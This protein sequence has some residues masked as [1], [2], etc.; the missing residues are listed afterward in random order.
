MP[1]QTTPDH[2][3]T[4]LTH[5]LGHLAQLAARTDASEQRILEAAEK[6]LVEVTADLDRLRPAIT[7]DEQ[8]LDDYQELTLE[9]GQLEIVIATARENLGPGA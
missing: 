2:H 6:R 4:G 5:R 9:R 1:P 3:R 7:T 8:A